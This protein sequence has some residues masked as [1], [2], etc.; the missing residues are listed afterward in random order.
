MKRRE[1]IFLVVGLLIGLMFGMVLIGGNDDLRE[2]LFGTAGSVKKPGVDH[3]LVSLD[4][5]QEWLAGEY[6]ENSEEMKASFDVLAKLPAAAMPNAEFVDAE[7]D[8]EYI[9]P[10]AYAVLVGQKEAEK[11]EVKSDDETSVC[12][13]LDDDPYQGATL[14]L[15]LTIPSEQAD[16]LEMTKDWEKLDSPKTNVLYWKLLACYPE[17]ESK[18]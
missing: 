4:T 18:S 7:K 10:Q 17:P 11:I 6:P 12:L 5:A 13:G 2:S 14:Y 3:Y 8:V 9:L 15:Y 1:T 16:K